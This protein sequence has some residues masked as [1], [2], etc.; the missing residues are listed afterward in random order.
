MRKACFAWRCGQR[1]GILASPSLSARIVRTNESGK[2]DLPQ[3]TQMHWKQGRQGCLRNCGRGSVAACGRLVSRDRGILNF[4]SASTLA[5]AIAIRL[6][7][8]S[9]FGASCWVKLKKLLWRDGLFGQVQRAASARAMFWPNYVVKFKEPTK[10]CFGRAI[11]P[12]SKSFGASYLVKFNEPLWREPFGQVKELLWRELFGQVQ[13]AALACAIW[14]SSKSRFGASYWVKLKELLW[15]V[16][17]AQ[18]LVQVQ[19][20]VLA[21]AIWSSSKS[22]FG[23]SCFGASYLVKIKVPLWRELFGPPP[24][25]TMANLPEV[26]H[27]RLRGMTV[28]AFCKPF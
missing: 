20:A 24:S 6:S 12:S 10:G 9:C 26:C 3:R 1:R 22:H 21:R 27:A 14:S 2:V 11:G 4:T 8:K 19:R 5:R 25:H 13:K 17:F 23:T 7:S 15:R 16:L 28:F 18:V